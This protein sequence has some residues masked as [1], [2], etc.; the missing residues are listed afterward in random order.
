MS[1]TEETLNHLLNKATVLQVMSYPPNS[2]HVLF[3]GGA[4]LTVNAG[5]DGLD[6]DV[7][8]PDAPMP[9]DRWEVAP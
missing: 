2:L 1:I 5:D 7:H 6:I 3:E 4:M 8:G 9:G